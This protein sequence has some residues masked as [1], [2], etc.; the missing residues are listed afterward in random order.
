LVTLRKFGERTPL[1]C[2]G[3]PTAPLLRGVE[4]FKLPDGERLLVLNF[5]ASRREEHAGRVLSPG[6]L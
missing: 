3:P 6:Y 5:A 1:A 4:Q 2:G